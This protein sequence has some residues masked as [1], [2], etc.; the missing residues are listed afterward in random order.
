MSRAALDGLLWVLVLAS[1]SIWF[2]IKMG[3]LR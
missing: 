2:M 1:L 3:E